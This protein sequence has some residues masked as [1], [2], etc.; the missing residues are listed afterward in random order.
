MPTP[1]LRRRPEEACL[2]TLAVIGG[3]GVDQ[4]PGL[5]ITATHQPDTPYGPPSRP[6]EEGRL[7]EA[8][9]LFLQRHGSRR[10][11]PHAPAGTGSAA[12]GSA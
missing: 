11:A 12:G 8:R 9:I 6:I 1:F 10:G 7:G 5:E 4:L 2:S 3:T